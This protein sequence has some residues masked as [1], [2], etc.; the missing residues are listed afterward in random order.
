MPL[1]VTNANLNDVVQE[2]KRAAPA[3][4]YEGHEY[5]IINEKNQLEASHVLMGEFLLKKSRKFLNRS[6]ITSLFLQKIGLKSSGLLQ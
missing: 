5:L 6:F 3:K 4:T 2:F 1:K